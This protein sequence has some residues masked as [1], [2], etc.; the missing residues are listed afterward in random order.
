MR[1]SVRVR[2]ELARRPWLFWTVVAAAAI[3]VAAS[4]LS[5]VEQ[6]ERRRDAWGTTTRVLVTTGDAEPGDPLGAVAAWSELPLAVVPPDALLE[7]T[8]DSRDGSRLDA[9]VRQRLGPGEVVT[10]HDVAP[11]TGPQALVPAGWLAVPLA[12]AVDSTAVVG[13]EVVVAGGGAVLSDEGVVVHH[14]DGV[15]L[16]AV[17]ADAAAAVAGAR[18]TAGGV[19]LLLRP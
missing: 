18:D 10:A 16:V 5:L 8:G 14:G 17:P 3:A 15:V 2:V 11:G 6:V 7:R 4:A 12:E 13:D 1:T 19:A 9:T